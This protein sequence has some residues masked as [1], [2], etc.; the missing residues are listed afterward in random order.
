MEKRPLISVIVPIYNA[1]A[2]IAKCVDSLVNQSYKTLE[3][4][5][6]DDGSTDGSCAICDMY[7]KIDNR[8][9]VIH[10]LNAGVSSARNT[11]L[12]YAKGEYLSFVDSDDWVEPCLY[13]TYIK[14]MD[15]EQ[16]SV[17]QGGYFKYRANGTCTKIGCDRLLTTPKE[18]SESLIQGGNVWSFLYAKELIRDIRFDESITRGEDWLFSYQVLMN[19]EKVLQISTPLYHYRWTLG[20]STKQVF[21]EKNLHRILAANRIQEIDHRPETQEAVHCAIIWSKATVLGQL[22][23]LRD[24]QSTYCALYKKLKAETKSNTKLRMRLLNTNGKVY[25]ALLKYAFPLWKIAVRQ[26]MK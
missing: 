1:E 9:K 25:I 4:I 5:L 6:V 2:Y 23:C 8:V 21:S 24:Y 7:A 15:K 14:C 22:V 10:K 16:V 26:Y 19:A 13:E 17:I 20:A 11:G 3:I 18:I 12:D